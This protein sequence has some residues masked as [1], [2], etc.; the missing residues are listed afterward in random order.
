MT[1]AALEAAAW[2]WSV[3]RRAAFERR[4]DGALLVVRDAALGWRATPNRD[5]A[6]PGGRFTT[7]PRGWRRHDAA[8]GRPLLVVLGD[9]YTHAAGVADGAAYHDAI[10][11][12]LGLAVAALGVNGYGTVQE[13]LVAREAAALVP[14]PA[15]VLLQMSDND[16]INNS[17]ALEHRSYVNNNLMPRPYLDGSGAVAIADPRRLHERLVLGRELTRRVLAG[18]MRTV[19]GGIEAGDAEAVALYAREL[20][21]TAQA[22]RLLRGVFP[23]AAALA[24]NVGGSWSR[25]GRDLERLAREAGFAYADL[26]SRFGDPGQLAGIVQADGAHWNEAGHALA[27]RILAEALASLLASKR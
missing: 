2:A 11:R 4:P 25:I 17:P 24:F 6:A 1:A 14:R 15:V 26:G 27:G 7:G 20:P 10:A 16:P 13:W 12:R 23:D 22:L 8:D 9:S 5:I 3:H 19:E 18:R 21:R